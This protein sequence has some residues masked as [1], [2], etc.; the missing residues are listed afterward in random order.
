MNIEH[1]NHNT[2][3][4]RFPNIDLYSCWLISICRV[5][6]YLWNALRDSRDDARNSRFWPAYSSISF[7]RNC[8]FPRISIHLIYSYIDNVNIDKTL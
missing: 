3:E 2:K 6:I 4:M 7:N 8:Y 5:E 1:E